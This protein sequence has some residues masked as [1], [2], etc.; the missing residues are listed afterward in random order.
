MAINDDAKLT[1]V[2]RMRL[3]EKEFLRIENQ[4]EKYGITKSDFAR[5]AILKKRIRYKI[6]I[7]FNQ[8]FAQVQKDF[9]ALLKKVN[10][11]KHLI[12]RFYKSL[13]KLKNN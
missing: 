7:Q 8:N 12:L 3:T 2:L 1:E 11:K 5:S 9:D 13:K 4:C 10:V 6:D